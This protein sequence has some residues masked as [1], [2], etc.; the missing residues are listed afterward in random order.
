MGM[1]LTIPHWFEDD[2]SGGL[3]F[4]AAIMF[5]GVWADLSQRRKTFFAD[6][7]SG[8]ALVTCDKHNRRV[9]QWHE[10]CKSNR[11]KLSISAKIAQ[12]N[13]VMHTKP[14]LRVV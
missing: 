4:L 12:N 8:L 13:K 6:E 2:S 5:V 7:S 9:G 11:L 3:H 1:R 14:V 10:G